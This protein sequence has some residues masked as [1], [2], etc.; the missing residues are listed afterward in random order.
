MKLVYIGAGWNPGVKCFPSKA[1][2]DHGPASWLKPVRT[3][4]LRNGWRSSGTHNKHR[5]DVPVRP[6]LTSSPR[7]GPNVLVSCFQTPQIFS[8]SQILGMTDDMR[9]FTSL[10]SRRKNQT[11][12]QHPQ[13]PFI[14]V[15]LPENLLCHFCPGICDRVARLARFRKP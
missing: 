11:F 9:S 2:T 3:A 10:R 6:G 12:Q 14:Q 7:G 4:R 5:L 15:D 13:L 1:R 8:S